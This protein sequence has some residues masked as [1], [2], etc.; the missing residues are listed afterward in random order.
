MVALS[1][2]GIC[3]AMLDGGVSISEVSEVVDVVR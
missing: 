1:G 3:R 2:R